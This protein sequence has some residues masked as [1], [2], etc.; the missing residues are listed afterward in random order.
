MRSWGQVPHPARGGAW[1]GA[2]CGTSV[3]LHGKQNKTS[4]SFWTL[5]KMSKVFSNQPRP[6]F[7]ISLLCCAWHAL[8]GRCLPTFKLLTPKEYVFPAWLSVSHLSIGIEHI[9]IV[10]HCV[11]YQECNGEQ[12]TV[13]DLNSLHRLQREKKKNSTSTYNTEVPAL[14]STGLGAWLWGRGEH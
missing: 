13:H 12:D 14:M 4:F 3:V 5:F 11:R 7:L 10:R 9:C 1:P 2:R 8:T 6:R